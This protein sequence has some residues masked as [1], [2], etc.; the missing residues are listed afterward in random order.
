[1]ILAITPERAPLQVT[2]EGAVRI[3]NTR[4]T[5]DTIV[6]VFQQGATAEEIAYRY[7]SLAL[8]DIYAT[9]AFYLNHQTEV[10]HYLHDRQQ[11]AQEI[12]NLNE[13][14]FD[15]QGLRDKLLARKAQKEVC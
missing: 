3:G 8:A 10:E 4:V 9:I 13:T 6:A 2:D 1:M 11:Q 7:P 12:R 15:P 5:L 14:R